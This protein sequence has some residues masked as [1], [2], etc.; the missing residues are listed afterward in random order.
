MLFRSI[1]CGSGG[2]SPSC[3]SIRP[4]N[5]EFEIKSIFPNPSAGIFNVAMTGPKNLDV[6]L[7]FTDILGRNITSIFTVQK[8]SNHLYHIELNGGQERLFWMIVVSGNKTITK[9]IILQ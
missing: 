5:Q 2:S 6:D 4:E 9:P 3:R 1:G 8:V 7:V